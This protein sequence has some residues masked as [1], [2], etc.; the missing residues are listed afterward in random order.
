MAPLS[1]VAGVKR[2]APAPSLLPPFEP[3]SS[4]PG[5]PRPAKR[6]ARVSA[7]EDVLSN[8]KYPTPIPTSS[9][10]IIPSSPPLPLSTRRPRM[11][12]TQ[13]TVSE[14]APL[15]TVPSV[16]LEDSGEP[17]LMGRS[18][19]SSHYQLSANR[20]I[21]R[22]HVRVAYIPATLALA[23]NKVEVSCMGWNGV[24]V[25]C[26]GRAWELGKGDSFTSE[27]EDAD[28]ML[29]VQDARVVVKW[30]RR[31]E[32]KSSTSVHSDSTWDDENSPRRAIAAAQSQSP[33]SSPLRRR[34]R[35][36]SPVSP[37][38]AV[39]AAFA[40]SSTL[41]HSDA[42]APPV[43]LVYEDE[44]RPASPT[45]D[46]DAAATSQSTQFASQPLGTG[47]L[48]SHS[49]ALTDSHDFSD[50]DEENDPII[51]SFG[52][53]G[54]NLLPRMASFTAGA[55]PDQR[56][57]HLSPLKEASSSPQRRSSSAST[58][59]ADAHNVLNHVMNQLAFSRLSSTPIS[60]I[61]H[62]LPADLKGA[63][64]SPA[65]S[66]S[67]KENKALT[68]SDLKRMLD[69]T[70]CVGEVVREG[71]DAAG[72][73]LQSEYY[74]IPELDADES[75][76]GAVVDG[77][78]KPGLR[79]CRKQH[80]VRLLPTLHLPCVLPN[81]CVSGAEGTACRNVCLLLM[82]VAF[83]NITGAS[84]KSPEKKAKKPR[85]TGTPYPF[86]RHILSVPKQVM[87]V[88]ICQQL[89]T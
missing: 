37:S 3:F 47:L 5:L 76:R 54:D 28:I 29:D 9:T 73:P 2:P 49:T 7:A 45:E 18:S 25:H 67:C 71:K 75:R 20:L 86:S 1:P 13:S 79:A 48:A 60:T 40:T 52:P 85:D 62:N 77:L 15:S 87:R 27:T 69:A 80:K 19:N 26:Q 53:F 32:R 84:R 16:M 38:P 43:I 56:R 83:S 36:Q 34:V 57:Q 35:L 46:Q 82:F 63:T 70:P 68:E 30:P 64:T 51:H 12:R 55:S 31:D 44:R 59:S 22:V 72:K 66:S 11:Q 17:V 50:R 6:Q 21:S 41:M 74:Y 88:R 61:L 4:S 81:R 58:R 39:Q 23:P 89:L 33:R 10:G 78:K 65:S 42:S 24:K 8:Q 14:R